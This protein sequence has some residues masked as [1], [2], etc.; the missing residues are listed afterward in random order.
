MLYFT[1]LQIGRF[2]YPRPAGTVGFEGNIDVQPVRT[3]LRGLCHKLS[4]SNPLQV[5]QLNSLILFV[6]SYNEDLKKIQLLIAEENTWQGNIEQRWPYRQVK[7][8]IQNF[9]T[10]WCILLRQLI[11]CFFHLLQGL[12]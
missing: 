1:P 8:L 6:S 10:R 12:H 5:D 11:F 4:F 9:T 2:E 7:L 3:V